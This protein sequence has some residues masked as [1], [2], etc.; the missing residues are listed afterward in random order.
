MA[1]IKPAT[2]F[3]GYDG[4]FSV[5]RNTTGQ[6]GGA[7]GNVNAAAI[8][9]TVTGRDQASFEWVN[10]SILDNYATGG[11]N[12]AFYA[13][14]NKHG[15]GPT[16]AAVSEATDTAGSSGSLVAHE[17]DV[18]ATGADTGS[19]IGLDIVSGDARQI[20]GLGR[21]AQADATT[22]IRVGQTASTPWAT[23]GTGIELTGVYRESAI[24][25]VAPN[26]QVVFEVKPDGSIYRRGVLLP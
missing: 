10:L 5:T 16:F 12:V 14:A 6:A 20:R 2:V 13:Q 7:H 25:I 4:G 3:D 24:K 1:I 23:W 17:F 22:A 18:F 15:I 8:F 19:R 11:E 26:G 21:S 9:H